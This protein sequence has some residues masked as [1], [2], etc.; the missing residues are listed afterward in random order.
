MSIINSLLLPWRLMGRLLR[1]YYDLWH[2]S[3][4]IAALQKPCITIF[5]S[6]LIAV[7][8]QYTKEAHHI[9][10]QLVQRGFTILT[11]GGPGIMQSANCGAQESGSDHVATLGIGVRGVDEDFNNRCASV[12][13]A[14]TFE[15]RKQL[16]IAY[17]KGFVFL[18]GGVG[19]ADE[20]F[21]LLNRRKHSLVQHGPIVLIGKQ[22]WQ[23]L[24]DWYQQALAQGYIRASFS[25]L[26]LITDDSDVAVSYITAMSSYDR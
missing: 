7:D 6:S 13:Y 18:P 25:Q 14:R 4:R 8:N 10:Q 9:A 17:S 23:P 19:T 2:G 3:R 11:G 12:I 1:D 16:L 15:T 24:I 5:G 20:L 22:F 21:D 26:F